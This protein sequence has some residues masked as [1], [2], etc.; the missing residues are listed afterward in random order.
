MK[1][2]IVVDDEPD[3]IY[4][5]KVGLGNDFEIIESNSGRQLFQ[6]LESCIPD[7][8]LLDI[9]IPDMNGWQ[10]LKRLKENEKL[11]NIPIIIITARTDKTAENAG[12]FYAEGYF[13]KP[14]TIED[15]KGSISKIL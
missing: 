2:I 13:E 4:S 7:L 8:V 5:I 11:K 3:I 10:I 1:K 9:M 14:F 12:R 6:I 15:L